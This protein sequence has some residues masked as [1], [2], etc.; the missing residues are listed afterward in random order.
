M[1]HPSRSLKDRS[2]ESYLDYGGLAWEVSEVT[3]LATGLEN[4]C[5]ILTKLVATFCPC[6]QIFPET[7]F[8]SNRLI[9]LVEDIAGQP[10]IDSFMLLVTT[11]MQVYNENEQVG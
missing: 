7:K 11:L 4:F 1:D 6:P 3:V 5:D 9:S 10:N 2:A 8:K